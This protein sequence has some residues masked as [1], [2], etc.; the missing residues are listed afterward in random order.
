MR[1]P[2]VSDER[3]IALALAVFALVVIGALVAGVFF[4]GQLES[5]AGRNT[6]YAAQAAEAAEAGAA[7]ELSGWNSGYNSMTVGNTAVG[8][9]SR[10]TMGALTS[11]SLAPSTATSSALATTVTDSITR[12]TDELFLIRSFGERFRFGGNSNANLIATHGVAVLARLV[13]ASISANAALTSH[14][15]VRVGGNVSIDGNDNVPSGWGGCTP[16][17]AKPGIRTSGVVNVN[18]Q[19]SINGSPAQQEHDNS[20]TDAMI[21]GPYDQIKGSANLVFTGDQN[22][23]GM[24]PTLNAANKCNTLNQ[25]N[26]G[27]PQAG[28]GA[29]TACQSYAP[30][31]WVKGNLSVQ[32]GRGQG[33]LL[34][35]GDL[36]IRGNFEFSGIVLVLGSLNSNGTG[37]KIMGTVMADNAD[38]GD[39]TDLGGNPQVLFSSCAVSRVL[40]LSASPQPL[41]SRNYVQLYN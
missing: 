21:R 27:E 2:R 8:S 31:I 20:V 29:V 38:I 3:G 6:T 14:G 9:F 25:L 24:A 4:S 10:T 12:L 32:T 13:T 40:Q 16:T 18:G 1:T 17:A 28:V 36:N 23:N 7:A 34:V 37:N 15:N 11:S 35:D 26:W 5:R 41:A 33:I 22:M 19:P 39:L 30:I